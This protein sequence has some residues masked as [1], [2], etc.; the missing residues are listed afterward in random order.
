MTAPHADQLIEGYLARLRAAAVDLPPSVR[1]ELIEDMRAHIAEARSREP[2]ETDATILNILDRLGEPDA[3]VAEAGRRPELFGSSQPGR[4]PEPY[5]PGILE[6]ASIILLPFLWPVGVILLWIS[7]AWKLRDKIIGT[8]L[9]PGGYLSIFYFGLIA[10]HA[11]VI[12]GE[13]N[14]CT[15]SSDSAG[16]I[17]TSCTS[18]SALQVIGVILSVALLIVLWLLPLITAG[19][20][21]VRLRWGRRRQEAVA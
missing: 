14:S 3:V 16:N 20:L 8:L 11:V 4:R 9:P 18:A 19:Y 2:Q 12:G 1:D 17:Q 13:G 5:Q 21:A 10:G 6:I 7:P 15:S